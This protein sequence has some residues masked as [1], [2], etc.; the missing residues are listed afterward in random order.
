MFADIVRF[1]SLDEELSEA[2]ASK[3]I[4]AAVSTKTAAGLPQ[5]PPDTYF[6]MTDEPTA[7]V[8]VTATSCNSDP[9]SGGY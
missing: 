5:P 9:Y 6:H 4:A 8:I 2:S 7:C 3:S 1:V